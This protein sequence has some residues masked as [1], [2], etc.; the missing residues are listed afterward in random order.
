[1]KVLDLR[2]L[3]GL[4]ETRD[5]QFFELRK[6]ENAFFK[7]E[8]TQ[9]DIIMRYIGSKVSVIEDLYKL[10]SGRVPK[11]FFCDPFGGV[12]TIGSYFKS[13][14]FKVYSGDFLTFANFFQIA[15]IT[16]DGPPKFSVLCDAMKIK[17]HG[18][19]INILN[20]LEGKDG[21][22]T[23]N[24][25]YKRKFFTLQ[26]GKKIEACLQAIKIWRERR[27]L[28]YEE[29]AILIASLINSMDKVANTAGTYYAYLKKWYRKA[30]RPFNFKLI[31]Y[32]PGNPYC[33]CFLC[34]AI[35]LVKRYKFDIIY[36][37]PPYNERSYADYY[38][39][40]ETVALSETPNVQ[41]KSGIPHV[42][43]TKSA[44]NRRDKALSALSNILNI[45]RF[46]LLVFHY[47]D[48]GIIRPDELRNLFHEFGTV[49]EYLIDSVGYTNKSES[50]T[51]KHRL[52]LVE[53]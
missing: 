39:L 33:R 10:I 8:R 42:K 15:R 46:R 31:P 2:N 23:K 29:N 11:G 49:D 13:K 17:N 41:G 3:G 52:Y 38:H 19:A 35:D 18:E 37:D 47:S 5:K 1:M 21:W 44:F 6:C 51:I 45:A 22:F 43:R 16:Q 9:G 28:S 20:N 7:I 53:S 4:E 40:P 48:D 26:N 25:A 14:N 30:T 36:L 27:W 50:R 34:D 24:Y 32:T 12:G